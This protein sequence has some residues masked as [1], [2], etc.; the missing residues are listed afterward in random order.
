MGAALFVAG[1]ALLS[2]CGTYLLDNDVRSFSALPSLPAN[3]SYRFERLP[4]QQNDQQALLESFADGALFRAGLRRD[5][6]APRYT[7]QLGARVQRTLSPWAA[8][9]D[10]W[11]GLMGPGPFWAMPFPRME[12]PWYRREVSVIVRELSGNKVVY[13]THAVSEGPWS[14]SASA[15]PAMFDA[16]LQGFP[17]APAGVRKVAVQLPQG[18]QA[19]PG[20]QA[21]QAPK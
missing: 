1:A 15:L 8:P 20:P 17:T 3:P 16:A 4:S 6:A 12:S 21:P 18:R 9:D 7:V 11:G 19:A 14:D 5:D 2:G 13:E 10:G